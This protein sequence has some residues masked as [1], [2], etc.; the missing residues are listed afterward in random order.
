MNRWKLWNLSKAKW[1][2]SFPWLI[3]SMHKHWDIET[4]GVELVSSYLN[5]E[6]E[7]FLQIFDDHDEERKFDP[8]RL[9]RIRRTRDVGRAVKL[10]INSG[11]IPST[12]VI[13]FER[14]AIR[15]KTAT[16]RRLFYSITYLTLVPTISRTRDWMSLSVIRFMWP[17][18]TWKKE[19]NIVIVSR[20]SANAW[21]DAMHD[22]LRQSL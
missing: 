21:E 10:W 19:K 5:F 9:F 14:S 12:C 7:I 22:L 2:I 8:Q 20:S 17:L 4:K 15:S 16:K 18:R 13:T 6:G 11:K 1:L 3:G